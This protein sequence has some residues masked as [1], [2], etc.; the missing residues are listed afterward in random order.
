MN[1]R[2]IYEAWKLIYHDSEMT[3]EEWMAHYENNCGC[4][5]HNPMS[6][7]IVGWA[8]GYRAGYAAEKGN[9]K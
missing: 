5:E 7:E 6:F 8:S 9:K 1:N 4:G 2:E 3:F